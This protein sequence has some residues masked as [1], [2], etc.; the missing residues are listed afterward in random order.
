MSYDS[1]ASTESVYGTPRAEGEHHTR[2]VHH[3]GLHLSSVALPR[4]KLL[5]GPRGSS[6]SC[7]RGLLLCW[8]GVRHRMIT[9]FLLSEEISAF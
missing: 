9:W 8:R 1:L 5:C 7:L 3:S 6:L 4:V 2:S